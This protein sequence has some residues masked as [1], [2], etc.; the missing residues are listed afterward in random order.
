METPKPFNQENAPV[1]AWFRPRKGESSNPLQD[2]VKPV[3]VTSL[4]VVF[5]GSVVDLYRNQGFRWQS[6]SD[7]YE[8]SFDR[9][10]WF[11]ANQEGLEQCLQPKA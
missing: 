1:D 9:V 4:G 10:H 7:R 5:A 8:F 11:P 2:L 3:R 6:L